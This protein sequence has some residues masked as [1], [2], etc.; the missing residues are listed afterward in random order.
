MIGWLIY[1]EEDAIHNAAYIKWFQEEAYKQGL[2]LKLIY[3]EDLHIGVCDHKR[4]VYHEVHDLPVFAVVRTREPLL[5]AL[6]ES[7]GIRCFNTSTV[8]RICNDK[9]LTYH[10]VVEAGI[11]IPD[12]VFTDISMLI[13]SPPPFPYP[14]I[15][16]SR[17]G[18]GGQEVWL[19]QNSTQLEELKNA[20]LKESVIVQRPAQFGKDVRV[21][22]VGNQIV[23][24]V[25]R[26]NAKDF[27]SNYSL[28]GSAALYELSIEEQQAVHGILDLFQFDLAGIDFMFSND[29]TL[30]FNEIED[31]VGSRTLSE[32]SSINLLEM[33]CTHIKETL[34]NK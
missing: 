12:T 8:A 10:H 9:A 17:D 14:F 4:S 29:G 5:T 11:A 20:T 21:F 19:I 26:H 31:V 16:K 33:Y 27:K 30:L 2:S 13:T 23:S 7:L 24:A 15:I 6:L 1:R 28:G 25:L 18:H 34:K 32:V 3:R 22:I